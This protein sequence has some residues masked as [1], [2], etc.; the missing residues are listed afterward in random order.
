MPS[1]KS[2]NLYLKVAFGKEKTCEA[3]GKCT[4]GETDVDRSKEGGNDRLFLVIFP[5]QEGEAA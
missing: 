3:E 1:R 4:S 2:G 5:E